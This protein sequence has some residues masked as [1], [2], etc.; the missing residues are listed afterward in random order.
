M[1]PT[2]SLKLIINFK[3]DKKATNN[4]F[5]TMAD[6]PNLLVQESAQEDD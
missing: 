6:D 5:I 3:F 2:F 1:A 4:N